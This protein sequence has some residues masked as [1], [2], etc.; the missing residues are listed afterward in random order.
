MK[1]LRFVVS[2]CLF[3]AADLQVAA[4]AP[5]AA[6]ALQRELPPLVTMKRSM[7]PYLGDPKDKIVRL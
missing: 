2:V 3:V 5:A 6:P 7:T 1:Q 4:A